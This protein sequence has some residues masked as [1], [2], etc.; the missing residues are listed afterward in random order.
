MTTP[1][2]SA[3]E[4]AFAARFP[5][6]RKVVA[7]RA[8]E[9]G[10]DWEQRFEA[11]IATFFAGD[12]QAIEQAIEGYSRFSLEAMRLQKKFDK[13]L[14]YDATSYETALA[15]VYQNNDYMLGTYLPALLMSHYLWPH[16]YRQ[17]LWVH[18]HFLP[19]VRSDRVTSFCDV[20][21]GT[22]FYSKEV[23]LGA[24]DIR[25]WG[26]DIS[27]ASLLQTERLL[28]RWQVSQ[29]YTLCRQEV[30]AG[31]EGGF[32]AFVSVELLEHLDDPPRFLAALRQSVRRGAYGLVTAALDA[33]NRDHIYLY[34][35]NGSVA[36]QLKAAGF[37]ILVETNLAAYPRQSERETVPQAACF[38]LQAT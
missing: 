23:L 30:A 21:I 2:I 33:P 29:R 5:L 19:K 16:H 17:L 25:G 9:F 12:P 26:Y 28:T 22:G 38:I 13:T 36:A 24:P 31:V 15:E 18:E 1:G 11:E 32:D 10:R 8:A 27:D 35:D 34:R 4:A 20:G 14:A 37:E 7:T 6:F 3:V